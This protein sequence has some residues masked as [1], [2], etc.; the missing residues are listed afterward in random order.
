MNGS[1]FVASDFSMISNDA[2]G[3]TANSPFR[4]N[5]KLDMDKALGSF[6]LD[7]THSRFFTLHRLSANLNHSICLSSSI[8]KRE[9]G[10]ALLRSGHDRVIF[11]GNHSLEAHGGSGHF[12]I[13]PALNEDHCFYADKPAEI[14]YFE[15]NSDYMDRLL[16]DLSYDNRNVSELHEAVMKDDFVNLPIQ[17]TTTHARIIS[18]ILN[19]SLQGTLGNLMLEGYLQ[20]LLAYQLQSIF[21]PPGDSE[22]ISNKDRE[23]LH[24]LKDHLSTSLHE[25]HTLESLARRFGI[26]QT[27]LTTHCK[28]MFGKPVFQYI[29]DQKMEYAQRL[30]LDAGMYVGEVASLVGYKN[31]NH[32]ATAFKRRFGISPSQ[33]KA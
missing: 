15:I 12:V 19:C 8:A 27:K 17:I 10:L 6:T 21:T 7:S 24:A 18:D 26:N 32:F 4:T 13:N 23:A 20:Q 3:S 11:G 22:S 33:L 5:V 14:D 28:L 1:T 25:D 29:L 16:W 30:L 9:Y 31:P 2:H